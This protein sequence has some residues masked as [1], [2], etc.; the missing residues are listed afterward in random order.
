MG[1]GPFII[2]FYGVYAFVCIIW[3]GVTYTIAGDEKGETYRDRKISARLFFLT[4]IWPLG[5]L[6]FMFV[7]I[8]II[9]TCCL[10]KMWYIAEMPKIGLPRRL[11][12]GR[13]EQEAGQLSVSSIDEGG[14]SL[15]N[16]AY[17]VEEGGK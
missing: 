13:V 5:L 10:G 15:L 3:A 6:F 11:T 4:P 17:S 12:S 1:S 8:R 2:M 14:L 9:L 16:E 7:G